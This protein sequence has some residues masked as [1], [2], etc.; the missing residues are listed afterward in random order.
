[1]DT[2]FCFI[3]QWFWGC[4]S[5]VWEINDC[6]ADVQLVNVFYIQNKYL[7]QDR[8]ISMAVCWASTYQHALRMCAKL[9]TTGFMA[10][11]QAVYFNDSG[12]HSQ[13]REWVW[14]CNSIHG[15]NNSCSLPLCVCVC[16]RVCLCVREREREKEKDRKRACVR[17]RER[18]REEGMCVCVC[19]QAHVHAHWHVHMHIFYSNC[20]S[21]DTRTH[22]NAHPPQQNNRTRPFPPP[23]LQM[24]SWSNATLIITPHSYYM[25]LHHLPRPH[26]NGKVKQE[27]YTITSPRVE[28]RPLS[29]VR[30]AHPLPTGSQECVVG[31]TR[32]CS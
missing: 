6:C 19:V 30:M 18:V 17:E 10:A 22:K 5:L 16:V 2:S 4:F 32:V 15:T 9:R 23:T 13:E 3:R 29:P 26:T 20:H 24:H 14:D 7:W 25:Y 12:Q 27:L 8:P 1:M 21:T 28:A 31:T 11:L